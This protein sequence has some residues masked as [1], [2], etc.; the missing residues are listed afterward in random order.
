MIFFYNNFEFNANWE[1][2]F[3]E[4]SYKYAQLNHDYAQAIE[5]RDS[6]KNKI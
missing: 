2:A 3:N 4:L 1:Q 5:L 6:L